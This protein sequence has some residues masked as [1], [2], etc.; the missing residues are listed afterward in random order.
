VKIME[1]VTILIGGGVLRGYT[2]MTL[3]RKKSNLTG[4]ATISIFM[5]SL[6]TEAVLAPAVAGVDVYIYIAGVLAFSGKIDRRRDTGTV[7]ANVSVDAANYSISIAARG[8][9]GALVDSSHA[10]QNGYY[11][12]ATLQ[13]IVEDLVAPWGIGVDW[14]AQD[15]DVPRHRLRDGAYV[16]DE[17]HR[18]GEAFSL[19]MWEGADGRL[20]VTDGPSQ[21]YGEPI[22]LGKNI[23]SFTTDHLGDFDR[24]RIVVKGQ[25][26]LPEA[27][28]AE[29]ILPVEATVA[30]TA[31]RGNS[32]IVVQHYGDGDSDQ[33]NKR[34]RY[35]ASRRNSMSKNIRL[36]V[37][38]V[39]QQ[40][41]QP[42]DIGVQHFV[43][44]PPA[45]VSGMFE[46]V[47]LTHKVNNDQS[48]ATELVLAPPPLP[49][50]QAA[51][52]GLDKT[53][54]QDSPSPSWSGPELEDVPAG[55]DASN[56]FDWFQRGDFI[57]PL[58]GAPKT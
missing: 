14:R 10:N 1:P 20:V 6:P 28:G 31:F 49:A 40:N 34:V 54:A 23:L 41:G 30:N 42:W 24:H 12:D 35:E 26:V 27:W 51:E 18:L 50:A 43:S 25:R 33:L 36:T 17:L 22:V 21:Q 3:S 32:A 13:D 48:I 45:G 8:K 44:I 53:P 37:F 52:T 7:A 55:E 11:K 29:A 38:N 2:N 46:I 9:A 57:A 39:T 5:N 47:E 4:S 16:V 56:Y 15:V 58:K 19:Y